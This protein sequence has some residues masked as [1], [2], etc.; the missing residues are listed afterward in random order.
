MGTDV[1]R[2]TLELPSLLADLLGL[3]QL[4]VEADTLE[5]ALRAAVAARPGLGTHLFDERGSLRPHV[6]CLH[7]ERQSPWDEARGRALADGDRL[8]VLQAVSG[9]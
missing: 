2:V 6:L 9:G 5:E 1:A 8:R 3:S 7:N 4:Q